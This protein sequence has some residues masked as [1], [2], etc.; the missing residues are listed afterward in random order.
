MTINREPEHAAWSKN[1]DQL[2]SRFVT[3]IHM[4]QLDTDRVPV[5]ANR[6]S[7]SGN[8]LVWPAGP[9]SLTSLGLLRDS[10]YVP[11]SCLV[12]EVKVFILQ[13]AIY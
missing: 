12:T 8:R 9:I 1:K 7:G 2:A 4:I 13:Q 3:H 5:L 10:A 6:T 11:R